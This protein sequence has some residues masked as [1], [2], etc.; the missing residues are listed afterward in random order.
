MTLS[1]AIRSSWVVEDGWS[2][3]LALNAEQLANYGAY[4]RMVCRVLPVDDDADRAVSSAMQGGSARSSCTRRDTQASA[5]GQTMSLTIDDVID[6]GLTIIHGL[7]RVT[8]PKMDAALLAIGLVVSALRD[9]LSGKTTPEIVQADLDA[10]IKSV[11][12]KDAANDAADNAALRAK[13]PDLVK[14]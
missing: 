12:D 2:R 13:F 8:G 7:T 10:L 5:K 11:S 1:V 3:P 6:G 4:A 9:G 14:E